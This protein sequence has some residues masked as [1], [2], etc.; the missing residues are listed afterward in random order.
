MFRR[1][2]NN[3]PGYN[4]YL[5]EGKSRAKFCQIENSK[6]ALGIPGAAPTAD[7]ICACPY[8]THTKGTVRTD[9]TSAVT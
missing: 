5:Q 3:P 7:L 9:L 4:S 8:V 2:K 1:Y 6:Y